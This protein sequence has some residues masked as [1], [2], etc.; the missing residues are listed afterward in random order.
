MNTRKIL[1][2]LIIALFLLLLGAW[3][4]FGFTLDFMRF[5]AAEPGVSNQ[6]PVECTMSGTVV[7]CQRV[8]CIAEQTTTQIGVTVNVRA[9]G[10][11]GGYT[12][13]APG[14]LITTNG[15]VDGNNVVDGATVR[16]DLAGLKQVLVTS[17]RA[18]NEAL[19]DVA[20]CPITV[21]PGSTAL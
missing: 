16:Y 17:R 9:F 4:Y 10:G 8:A 7:T 18:S 21:I 15:S 5:F 3:W 19:T 1:F 12:F 14:G 20:S 2:A 6:I 13:T 11:I